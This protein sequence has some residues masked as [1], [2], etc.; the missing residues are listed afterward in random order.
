MHLAD[1]DA[2]LIEVS[3]KTSNLDHKYNLVFSEIP[4][5]VIQ[6]LE[7]LKII[8]DNHALSGTASEEEWLSAVFAFFGSLP[9]SSTLKPKQQRHIEEIC[10]ELLR[11]PDSRRPEIAAL[12]EYHI[13]QIGAYQPTLQAV[14][15]DNERQHMML[16]RDMFFELTGLKWQSVI[17][18]EH[19][20]SLARSNGNIE[21]V[22]VC[23]CTAIS[24]ERGVSAYSSVLKP[25][26]TSSIP[27]LNEEALLS[28]ALSFKKAQRL[29]KNFSDLKL[30]LTSTPDY[31]PD[32]F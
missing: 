19:L 24:P 4:P 14:M 20:L 30:R 23:F 16:A 31:D 18:A 13:T 9:E 25:L 11:D 26:F 15:N 1:Y 27:E 22:L 29:L 17:N 32:N 12:A 10:E 2:A 28:V 21:Q 8:A 7:D 6:S 5:G 3:D